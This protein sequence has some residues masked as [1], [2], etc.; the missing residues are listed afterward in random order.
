MALWLHAI[1]GHKRNDFLTWWHT[2]GTLCGQCKTD[3]H[4]K[5]PA[6][7]KDITSARP[8]I[9]F[10]IFRRLMARAL[11][12][13]VCKALKGMCEP[14]GQLG[15]SPSGCPA[16]YR[17]AQLHHD[18][19]PEWIHGPLDIKNAHSAIR[20]KAIIQCLIKI[21][22]ENHGPDNELHRMHLL[23]TLAHYGTPQQQ[24]YINTD[25]NPHHPFRIIDMTESL[26]QGDGLATPS[27]DV[28]YT[29]LVI[30]PLTQLFPNVPR[31]ILVC[32]DDTTLLAPPWIPPA[33]STLQKLEKLEPQDLK[34][35]TN[36]FAAANVSPIQIAR[37]IRDPTNYP[38][39]HP[40][41]T[42]LLNIA[43]PLFALLTGAL[44]EI[45]KEAAGLELA[46][47]KKMKFFQRH[48]TPESSQ[49]T[50]DGHPHHTDGKPKKSKKLTTNINDPKDPY[51]T[52]LL[53]GVGLH[54]GAY[55]IAGG[56]VGDSADITRR[57]FK[58]ITPWKDILHTM[59]S[60]N[61][62]PIFPAFIAI[63]LAFNPATKFGHQ[64]AMQPPSGT[65]EISQDLRT[66][67]IDALASLIQ[68]PEEDL[69]DTADTPTA[70]YFRIL[71]PAKEG[72][73]GITDPV[74]DRYI[75]FTTNFINTLP[76]LTQN[77]S[78]SSYIE[79]PASW[80]SSKSPTLK[81]AHRYITYCATLLRHSED[82]QG[83]TT[84]QTQASIRK[85]LHAVDNHSINIQTLKDV[86][87]K[88]LHNA[89]TPT[90]YTHLISQ[91]K[92]ALSWSE[93]DVIAHEAARGPGAAPLL[94]IYAIT[95]NVQLDR[96]AAQFLFCHRLGLRLPFLPEN[97]YCAHT[98]QKVPQPQGTMLPS[99][100]LYGTFQK[101]HHQL[102]CNHIGAVKAR[103]DIWLKTLQ[104]AL[105]KHTNTPGTTVLQALR[106]AD[107]FKATDLLLSPEGHDWPFSIDYTC[108]CAFL[109]KYRHLALQ[110][111]EE[112]HALLYDEKYQKHAQHCE[113]SRKTC[114]PLPGNTCGSFG[115]PAFWDLMDD[116]WGRAMR[117]AIEISGSCHDV[118]WAKQNTWASLHAITT[119]YSAN[120]LYNLNNMRLPQPTTSTTSTT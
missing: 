36:A 6:T 34:A 1:H 112:L 95:E 11:A 38:S 79:D 30:K 66:T 76:L 22:E 87:H 21:T 43:I 24:V 13:P 98:C 29:L 3:E 108:A 48:P 8:I 27:F 5:Y 7:P 35:L 54:E 49:E 14:Y 90:Y 33:G 2:T 92:E 115:T 110:G 70:A 72:G 81:D 20:R 16:I 19:H 53:P 96:M 77:H 12:P 26:P 64:L 104:H 103:H 68:I 50:T 18:L 47:G 9:K 86:A 58:T 59:A 40:D 10:P 114:L 71:L 55:K 75:S 37:H 57:I 109:K 74:S 44:A 105:A 23:W 42:K 39:P 73:F 99:N 107:S 62:C 28:T 69:Y 101:G 41:V 78:I 88:H 118:A 91:S 60:L 94:N 89:F 85:F 106:A 67:I 116:I 117:R 93:D 17:A 52:L 61:D 120:N 56:E 113:D 111:I 51:H 15:L 4:G 102:S 63:K 46:E 25:E 82:P 97:A 31:D 83:P 45:A 119:R 32:H 80:P 65:G 100:D 84:S